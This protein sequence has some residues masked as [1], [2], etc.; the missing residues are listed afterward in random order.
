MIT[1]GLALPAAAADRPSSPLPIPAALA[2][3]ARPVPEAEIERVYEEVKTPY[4]YG[5]IIQPEEGGMVDC[6]SVF[7]HDGKWFMAYVAIRDKTGYETYL[8]ES[9]NLLSWR[10]L[11]KILPFSGAGWDRWQA[12]GGAVLIDHT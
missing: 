5:I 2:A 11:G 1:F 9:D 12:D 3:A 10:P 6:P 4:K 7:R 8:A